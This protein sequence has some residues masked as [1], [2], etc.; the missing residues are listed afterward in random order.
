MNDV[1]GGAIS[2]SIRCAGLRTRKQVG[3]IFVNS[4]LGTREC[5]RW[6][7]EVTQRGTTT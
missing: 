4:V 3:N 5:L 7:V 6:N 1:A 2:R